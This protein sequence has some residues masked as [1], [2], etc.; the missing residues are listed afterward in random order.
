MVL[1]S[2]C[3]RTSVE[4]QDLGVAIDG[5]PVSRRRA[6]LQDDE[7]KVVA[8]HEV[9]HAIVGYRAWRRKV[10]ILSIVPFVASALGYTPQLP[11]ERFIQGTQGADRHASR[12]SF[13]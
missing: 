5:L 9:G 1:R 2:A 6:I 10:A 7:K 13:R 11:T 3:Q 12:W 8:Y 4:Q